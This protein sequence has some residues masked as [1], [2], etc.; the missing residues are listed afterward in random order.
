MCGAS[1]PDLPGSVFYVVCIWASGLNSFFQIP[2]FLN[3]KPGVGVNSTNLLLNIKWKLSS[4]NYSN[5]IVRSERSIAAVQ[6]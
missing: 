1:I 2:V 3:P 6:G 4:V 5:N